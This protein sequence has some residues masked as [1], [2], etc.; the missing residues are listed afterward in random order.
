MVSMIMANMEFH[1]KNM[2]MNVAKVGKIARTK[3]ECSYI[4]ANVHMF[5]PNIF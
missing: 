2:I 5:R 3:A 4:T 1:E